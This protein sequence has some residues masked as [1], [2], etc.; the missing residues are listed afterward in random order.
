[1]SNEINGQ[2]L[3]CN[4][5]AVRKSNSG[6]LCFLQKAFFL[7]YIFLMPLENVL[8]SSLGGSLIKYVGI[9][10]IGIN[11]LSI[12]LKGSIYYKKG[13]PIVILFCLYALISIIW[14]NNDFNS[15]YFII[16]LNML[17][18]TFT[19]TN[20]T[21]DKKFFDN[22]FKVLVISGLIVSIM[23]VF[24]IGMSSTT[25]TYYGE[26]RRTLSVDGANVDNNNLA[27]MLCLQFV[28]GFFLFLKTRKLR[29][30]MIYL[31]ICIL[32]LVAIFYTGSRGSLL[33]LA[34]SFVVYFFVSKTRHKI[35]KLFCAGLLLIF[36]FYMMVLILPPSV[37]Q[38]FSIESVLQTGGSGR[39]DIWKNAM[40]IF[41][42]ASF[43]DKLLGYG[44]S[45][46]PFIM[47]S[48]YNW[49]VA[50]HNDFVE[51]LIELGVLGILLYIILLA[52]F[53][54]LAKKKDICLVPFFII[55]LCS[56]VSMEML[57]KKMFWMV[58]LF[59]LI[60][61]NKS[62]VQIETTNINTNSNQELQGENV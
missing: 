22:I 15:S 4:E 16:I 38:R 7:I 43:K 48:S 26:T 52:S 53:F 37:T 32:M 59:I 27:T 36:A 3:S 57:V 42:E 13:M 31:S 58:I 18:F 25:K 45:S 20:T 12:L 14:A 51:V 61:P 50:A 41:Q 46:F 39:F 17:L 44:W 35:L 54:F 62:K 49:F 29:N 56:S 11:V 6:V 21:Y 28:A 19:F 30:K 9:V 55:V 40:T 23:V 2:V 1:M 33:G 34:A 8:A 24:G 10:I 47:E 60:Y 5:K